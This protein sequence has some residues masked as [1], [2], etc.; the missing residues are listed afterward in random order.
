MPV[1]L[2][3]LCALG[4]VEGTTGTGGP[5]GKLK[6]TT[7]QS[8]LDKL[9]FQTPEKRIATALWTRWTTSSPT[10]TATKFDLFP[11]KSLAPVSREQINAEE[12]LTVAELSG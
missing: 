8:G 9:V 2:V 6:V 10:M 12:K 7:V 4:P 11:S 5:G 1:P 3:V